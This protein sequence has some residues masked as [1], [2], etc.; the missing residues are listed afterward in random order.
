M[1]LLGNIEHV[2]VSRHFIRWGL[3]FS[4]SKRTVVGSIPQ[5]R[6][7]AKAIAEST[8]TAFLLPLHITVFHD[9]FITWWFHNICHYFL[10]LIA[11]LQMHRTIYI[12]TWCWT[13]YSWHCYPMI[14][15]QIQNLDKFFL[16]WLH[17]E[18]YC[19]KRILET[20]NIG[21]SILQ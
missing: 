14:V 10:Q 11:Q 13:S 16:T 17:A 21:I 18:I 20:A 2:L 8:I 4:C 15:V 7:N 6:L 1:G 5:Q 19:K 9:Y 12:Y 3:I